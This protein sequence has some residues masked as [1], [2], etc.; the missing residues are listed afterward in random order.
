MLSFRPFISF[1]FIRVME[2]KILSRLYE[3]M[4]RLKLFDIIEYESNGRSILADYFVISTA[5]SLL[6]IEAARNKII[7]IMEDFSLFLKNPLEEWRDGWC[8]LDFGNIIVHIFL[9]EIRR[10]YNL[11]GIYEGAGFTSKKLESS[12]KSESEIKN[13]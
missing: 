5:E 13:N 1:S 7:Y 8:L 4:R 9:E 2:E 11:E 12:S 6:Q 3:E 10:F